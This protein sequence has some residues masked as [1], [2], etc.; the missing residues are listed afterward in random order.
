[1]KSIYRNYCKGQIVI[2]F[3]ISLIALIGIVGLAID[4]GRAYGVKAKL[5][6]AV[7]AAS[8]SAARGLTIGATDAIR[9]ANAQAAAVKFYNANFPSNYL[10][11]TLIA[12]TVTSVHNSNG[13]WQVDVSG[14]ATM[15]TTFIRILNWNQISVAAS[16][17]AIRRDLDMIL[18]LDVS[19][20]LSSVFSTVKSAAASFVG[21]FIPT[22]D[23]IG[24]V[25]FSSGAQ[26]IVPIDKTSS[27]G[28]NSSTI[29]TAIN[30]L[31]NGGGTASAEGMRDALNEINAVPAAVRSSLRVIVFFS[32]GA[33]NELPATFS[34]T[35]GSPNQVTGDLYSETAATGSVGA[36][37]NGNPCALY[38]N[39]QLNGSNT[40][41]TNISDLP[42]N[43]GA[44]ITIT[45][46]SP[47]PGSIPL[48]P[49]PV[50]AGQPGQ[51]SLGAT[52]PYA[53]TRCNV[54]KAA[55]N[56]VELVANTARS[57]VESNTNQPIAIYTLGL[58]N[59]LNTLEITFCGYGSNENGA[60]IMKR[61]ANTTDSD[62][63]QSAAV[64]PGTAPQP[65]GLY[66][67]ADI[68]ANP[69]ALD[70]CFSAIASDI[71][72]LAK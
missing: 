34:R 21:K 60:N 36:C 53:N 16:G 70:S 64:P 38:P 45:N 58:G 71:L 1:M 41:Y 69:G 37:G 35:S 66:C 9:I 3:A 13:Y 56:M 28:F 68:T 11:A 48:V 47:S 32:D 61:L 14:S 52:P 8:I 20:S 59:A 4:S 5:S 39:D 54:N 22:T 10:G 67:Y 50:Q 30:G 27:R 6:A 40:S 43:S 55:R 29:T 23:R 46:F 65:N 51:R 26:L 25:A 57:W 12:P 33:P 2:L 17:T 19:G 49:N 31:T 15:P 63:L 44:T 18:V 7:D 24:L 72:R 42:N 62:T